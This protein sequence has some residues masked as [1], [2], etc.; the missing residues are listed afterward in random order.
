MIATYQ[1]VLGLMNIHCLL[2]IKHY[3][4]PIWS[5]FIPNRSAM[6]MDLSHKMLQNVENVDP[7]TGEMSPRSAEYRRQ[8]SEATGGGQGDSKILA[9]KQKAPTAREGEYQMTFFKS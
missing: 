3:F 1:V 8:L 7:K 9:F 2:S 5:R 6:D 4:T